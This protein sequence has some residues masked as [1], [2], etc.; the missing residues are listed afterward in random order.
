MAETLRILILDDEPKMG[1]ILTRILGREG[2]EAHS[3]TSPEEALERLASEPFDL[4][5]TDLKMPGMN[6]LEVMKRARERNAELDVIMMTA[7]A[8]VETAVEAM[9]EGAADYLIKPFENEELIML[10]ARLAETRALKRENRELRRTLAAPIHPDNVIAASPAMQEA[11]RRA[12]KVAASDVSVLLRGESGTGKEVLASYIHACSRRAD[13]PFVKVNCGAL[14]ETLLESELFG[15]V[16]GAFTGAVESRK[17]LFQVADG[18]T[19]LLDEIGEVSQALQVKLLRVLQFGEF[20]RVGDPTTCKVDIRLIASTNRSLEE[21]IETKQFRSDLFYR[22]NVV[23]IVIPPLRERP[24]DIPALIDHALMR[25][26]RS[27]AAPKRISS[28]AYDRLMTYGWPGNIRELE[29]AIE[30]AIVMSEGEEIQVEDLPLVV[31]NARLAAGDGAGLPRPDLRSLTLEEIEKRALWEALEATGFNHTKAARKL[32]ITRRTLG[33]RID[34][35]GL[36]RKLRP[37]ATES[38]DAE[39]NGRAEAPSTETRGIAS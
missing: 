25:Q 23:P 2:H 7:Y 29:N 24:E 20:Q 4:L 16:R 26:R 9:K 39:A 28:A 32:G 11:L 33:Y 35:Y 15:H 34:K 31:Q 18:G 5:L 36:P 14:P 30:H 38:S 10:V 12:H 13:Q 19:I 3:T 6:G 27:G 22:L 21:L 17:G 37:P 1:K 8:T